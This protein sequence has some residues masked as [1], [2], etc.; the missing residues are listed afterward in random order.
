MM[1]LITKGYGGNYYLNYSV[2]GGS[3][4]QNRS[5]NNKAHMNTCER[6]ITDSAN[7]KK[8]EAKMREIANWLSVS[9]SVYWWDEL[10]VRKKEGFDK[11]VFNFIV[12]KDVGELSTPFVIPKYIKEYKKGTLN[13]GRLIVKPVKVK[14]KT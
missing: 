13:K 14:N 5:I 11:D 2:Y 10:T 4:F 1:P 9:A 8:R 6:I 12:S 7:F 3:G